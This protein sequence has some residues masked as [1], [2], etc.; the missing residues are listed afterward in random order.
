[1]NHRRTTCRAAC[2]L[3]LACIKPMHSLAQD[4]PTRPVRWVVPFAPGGGPDVV[5]RIVGQK[6]SENFGQ[7]VLIDNRAGAGGNVGSAVVASGDD[8]LSAGS[9][10]GSAAVDV[11]LV[12]AAGRRL[13]ATGDSIS[14]TGESSG[15]AGSTRSSSM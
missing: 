6:L 1:M 14:S 12:S 8:A 7:P 10:R 4:Y 9:T 11:R 5:A 15:L 13:G 2:A 3:F